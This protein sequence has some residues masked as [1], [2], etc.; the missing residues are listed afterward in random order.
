MSKSISPRPNLR[1]FLTARGGDYRLTELPH[2]GCSG[3]GLDL[4]LIRVCTGSTFQII[5][6][7]GG[8]FTEAAAVTWL[9]L[10]SAR[11]DE[12]L[13]AYFDRKEGHGYSLCRVPMGSCDFALGNYAHVETPGD[14]DLAT[15]SIARDRQALIPFIRAAQQV[16]GE[17]IK[18]LASPWSPPAWMKTNG[19]MNQGGR[20]KAECRR[21]WARCYVRFIEAHAAEGLHICRGARRCRARP[22]PDGRRTRPSARARG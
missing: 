3:D 20:L 10:S 18:L 17:P 8:A 12:V 22:S 11:R 1:S 7:F 5:E 21:A 19:Q 6:G 4:P 2:Q 14:F 13:R 16:A 15:F 9:K